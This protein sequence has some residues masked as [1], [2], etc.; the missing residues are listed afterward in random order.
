MQASDLLAYATDI[1]PAA[2]CQLFYVLAAATVLAIAA[3]PDSVQSLLTQYG[4][5]SSVGNG[6]DERAGN[7]FLIGA[8]SRLTSVGKVPHSWFIHFY[9][10]SI[11]CS[12]FWAVQFLQHGSIMEF[13][14]RNQAS[15]EESSMAISQVILAWFL[16]SFQ[17]ARRLYENVAILRPSSS[18][19]WVIHWLLGAAFYFCTSIAVWIEGSRSIQSFERSFHN[20]TPSFKTVIG[21]SMFLASWFMQYRCHSYLS[22][23]KKYSLPEDGLFRYLVCPHYTCECTL[24]LSLAIVAAPK[25]QLYNRT[26]MCAVLFVAV[27]LGVTAKGTK[28]WYGEMF[29]LEKVQGKWRMI[30]GVF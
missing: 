2:C 23:L 6:K 30:P 7:G 15:S 4:A 29:G 17:G 21:V 28:K 19:M 22:R 14:V 12:I 1:S 18:K 25:D 11:S 8:I 16:M 3:T 5:R 9:I 20:E 27:N 13:I 10:L 26:L 24:Y